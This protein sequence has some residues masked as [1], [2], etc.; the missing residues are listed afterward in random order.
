MS[1]ELFNKGKDRQKAFG[2]ATFSDYIQA[3]VRADTGEAHV[4]HASTAPEPGRPK[5][6]RRRSKKT[7]TGGNQN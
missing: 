5:P 1:D 6:V 4:R 3:L 2:Y 7:L